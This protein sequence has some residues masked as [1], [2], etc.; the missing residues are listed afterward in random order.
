MDDK[1]RLY[2]DMDILESIMDNALHTLR[3]LSFKVG[4]DSNYL[5]YTLAEMIGD[6]NMEAGLKAM[7]AAGDYHRAHEDWLKLS[8]MAAR[9]ILK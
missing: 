7:K 8:K 4:V 2:R 9:L 1:E 3:D 5:P 6:R